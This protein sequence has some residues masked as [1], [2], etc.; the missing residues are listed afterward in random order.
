MYVQKLK[1]HKAAG[2]DSLNREFLKYISDD[3][4]PTLFAMYNCIFDRG[5]WPTKWAE[6][7]ISPVHK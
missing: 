4:I 1:I 6:G 5:E 2:A 3:I 7:I